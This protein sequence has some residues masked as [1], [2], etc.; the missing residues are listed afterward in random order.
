MC[1]EL[2]ANVHEFVLSP[3]L[4]SLR[5]GREEICVGTVCSLLLSQERNK[6]FILFCR[7]LLTI[8][9]LL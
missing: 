5:T 6:V 7:P 3:A 4:F 9:T 8:E 1:S 2:A